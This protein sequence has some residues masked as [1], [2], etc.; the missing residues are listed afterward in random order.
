MS[1]PVRSTLISLFCHAL[2]LAVLWLLPLTISQRF[3]PAGQQRV[4]AISLRLSSPPRPDVSAEAFVL[5]S[6]EPVPESEPLPLEPAES[7]LPPAPEPTETRLM[8]AELPASVE[9]PSPAEFVRARRSPPTEMPRVE[10]EQHE[11]LPR[12]MPSHSTPPSVDIV[13]LA[14]AV[15]LEPETPADFSANP[16]PQYPAAAV[17]QQLEGTVTLRLRVD[18]DGKVVEVEILESS[19]HRVLDL[20]AAEAVEQWQGKPAQRFGRAVASEEILP[21]RFRL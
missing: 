10:P 15:G 16:P 5:A 9:V 4:T 20:A 7:I 19:G 14:Q 1:L 8:P 3:R 6:V 17:R 11:T 2:V 21:V 18:P 12:R 13:P